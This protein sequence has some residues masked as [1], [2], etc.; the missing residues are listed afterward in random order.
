MVKMEEEEY[1]DLI[2]TMKRVAQVHKS[3]HHLVKIAD[4]S[5]DELF[6]KLNELDKKHSIKQ[7]GQ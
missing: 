6:M 1:K 3:I 2:H 7:G 4:R 5:L